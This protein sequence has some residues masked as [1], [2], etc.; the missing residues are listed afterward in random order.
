MYI[1]NN[2]CATPPEL[3]ANKETFSCMQPDYWQH[4]SWCMHAWF[5]LAHVW[6]DLK[7]TKIN[8]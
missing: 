2:A 7:S 6:F 4:L 5:D 8:W 1:R 3:A